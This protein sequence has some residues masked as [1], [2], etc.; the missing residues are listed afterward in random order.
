[1]S[2][3]SNGY[4]PRFDIDEADGHQGELFVEWAM[5]AILTGASVE[6]K[7]DRES[8]RTGNLYIEQECRVSGHWGPS[9]ID[10]FHTKSAVW[11][12]L[13]V[14]PQ[15]IFAPTAFVRLVAE[16]YGKPRECSSGSHPT[17]GKVLPIGQFVTLIARV[18][19][20]WAAEGNPPLAA[21]TDES[22]PFGRAPD[23]RAL[24]PWGRRKDGGACL[25]PGG[26]RADKRSPDGLWQEDGAA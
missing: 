21:V 18:A 26:R 12:H 24:A 17:R 23:G 13:V 11:A 19:R 7:T 9:G 4:E 2:R 5:K 10:G 15:V 16:K 6:I 20:G 8:W 3:L 22:A 1:M 25:Q 14:G